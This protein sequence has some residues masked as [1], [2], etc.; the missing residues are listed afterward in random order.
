MPPKLRFDDSDTWQQSLV[1]RLAKMVVAPFPLSV[2][3]TSSATTNA[4]LESNEAALHCVLAAAEG[5]IPR[6]GPL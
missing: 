2:D 6:L 5:R 1:Q 4:A 3:S